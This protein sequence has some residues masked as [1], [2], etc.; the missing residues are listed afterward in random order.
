MNS[1]VNEKLYFARLVLTAADSAERDA[2]QALLEAA[3]SHLFAAYRCYLQ[4]ITGLDAPAALCSAHAAA[5]ALDAPRGELNELQQLEQHGW[6]AQLLAAQSRI[7]AV[8]P[9]P[10]RTASELTLV[11]VSTRLDVAT[12]RDWLQQFRQLL[13]RQREHAQEW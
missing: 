2:Q 11:D 3:V 13:E 4:E 9:E 6:A 10:P 5:R 7:E 8:L 1:R 12:C